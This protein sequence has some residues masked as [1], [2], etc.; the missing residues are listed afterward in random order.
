MDNNK[1]IDLLSFYLPEYQ[2]LTRV[3]KR[4]ELKIASQS[5]STAKKDP[6]EFLSSFP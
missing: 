6:T 4:Y 5:N 1:H 3:M 2:W